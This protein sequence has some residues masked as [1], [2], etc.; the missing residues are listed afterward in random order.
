MVRDLGHVFDIVSS[1]RLARKYVD[2]AA[3]KEFIDDTRMQDAVVR[4]LEIIGEAAGRLSPGFRREHNEVPWNE[5]RGMRNRAIHGYEK[6]DLD[7][8]WTVAREHLATLIARLEP[9][10]PPEEE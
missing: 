7:I 2:G 9:L 10:L 6:L 4:R 3:Y 5:I 1:A 8:V